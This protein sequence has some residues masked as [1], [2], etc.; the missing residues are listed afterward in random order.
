MAVGSKPTTTFALFWR[1]RNPEDRSL[2][3][4]DAER[5]IAAD[6]SVWEHLQ[7]RPGDGWK[8]PAKAG[9]N[10][11][12]LMVQIVESWLL[13]DPEK[14]AEFYGKGFKVAKLPK[15]VNGLDVESHEK[16][17][18][19]QGLNAAVKE[20]KHGSYQKFHA[21]EIIGIIDPEKVCKVSRHA[22]EL[23]QRLSEILE[24]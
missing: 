15:P 8:K 24:P 10:D 2:I 13:A 5:S 1:I 11:A 16:T 6:V 22:R 21:F 9:E 23:T 3:V 17:K 20:T 14:L 4:V 18:V 19:F 12:H 7:Q